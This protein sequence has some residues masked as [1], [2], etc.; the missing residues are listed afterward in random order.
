M[1]RHSLHPSGRETVREG[2]M[3][4]E[5]PPTW[6]LEVTKGSVSGFRDERKPEGIPGR[7]R[8]LDKGAEE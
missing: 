5:R 4:R 8:S 2:R 3:S 1:T 7:G 6:V